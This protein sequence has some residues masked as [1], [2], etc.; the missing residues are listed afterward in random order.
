MP[1]KELRKRRLSFA[2]GCRRI[3]PMKSL[4]VMLTLLVLGF[5]CL[6]AHADWELYEKTKVNGKISGI[7]K[8]GRLIEMQSGSIY[9]VS[10]ITIQDVV[11]IGPEALVLRDGNQFKVFIDGFDELLICRQLVPQKTAPLISIRHI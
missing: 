11:Q 1:N 7:V 2:V 4:T 9:Q 5:F 6:Q 3:T 10:G 8:K